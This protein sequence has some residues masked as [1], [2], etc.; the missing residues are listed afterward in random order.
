MYNYH[1]INL[2]KR[3]GGI[4]TMLKNKLNLIKLFTCTVTISLFMGISANAQTVAETKF[5]PIPEGKT[6]TELVGMSKTVAPVVT[7]PPVK[8]GINPEAIPEIKSQIRLGGLDRIET[9]IKI[10]DEVRGSNKLNGVILA[11]YLNFPDALTGG[12]LNT[13]YDA[14]TLLIQKS[15][16]NAKRTLEYIENNL[17]K[18]GQIVIL[19]GKA[20]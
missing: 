4:L 14:P 15:A 20:L 8:E 19:G 9:S 11:S 18:N 1:F 5:D 12:V 17:P 13:K 16:D 7:V 2:Y 10:A 3:N 6:L